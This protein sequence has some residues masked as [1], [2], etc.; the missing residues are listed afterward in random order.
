MTRFIAIIILTTFLLQTFSKLIIYVNYELNLEYIIKTYCIN[1]NNPSKHCDG[2]CHLIKQ[3]QEEEKKE[4]LPGTTRN[5]MPELPL[6]S[7]KVT[8]YLFNNFPGKEFIYP[9]LKLLKTVQ[10]V[11]A[12]FHPPK[13]YYTILT[14]LS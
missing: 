14:S 2:K 7:E 13:E 12:F 1:K 10:L 9:E 3:M 5:E 6:F 8:A 11:Y 4:T